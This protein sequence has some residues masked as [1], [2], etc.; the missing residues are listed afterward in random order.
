MTR[1]EVREEVPRFFLSYSF[2]DRERA[3]ELVNLLSNR[4]DVHF[5]DSTM[6]SAGEDWPSWLKE[7]LL[8]SD[9]FLVLL[10]PNSLASEFVMQ[11]LDAAWA[12]DKPIVAAL[13]DTAT[14]YKLPVQSAQ[15]LELQELEKPEVIDQIID[16]Y[17]SATH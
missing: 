17:G 16:D 11:E 9:I 12:S 15:V 1:K 5:F 14:R 3:R 13:M 10:S 6:I 2:K 8:K 4:S 7:E